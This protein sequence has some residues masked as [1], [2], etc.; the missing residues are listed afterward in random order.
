MTLLEY[1]NADL[2][3]KKIPGSVAFRSYLLQSIDLLAWL[4]VN[5]LN[6]K[7][8]G[9]IKRKIWKLPVLVQRIIISGHDIS[10]VFF[11]NTENP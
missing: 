6:K 4:K 7:Y 1:L 5:H 9:M 10:R 8:T 3:R 11:G 2:L